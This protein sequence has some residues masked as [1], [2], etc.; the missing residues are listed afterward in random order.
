V[1][2]IV[3]RV[4]GQT[5]SFEGMAEISTSEPVGYPPR[6]L[7]IVIISPYLEAEADLAEVP[8]TGDGDGFGLRS[9]QSGRE[10]SS[11]DRDNGNHDQ[12]LDKREGGTCS[13][14]KRPGGY[15]KLSSHTNSSY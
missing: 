11:Q 12:E 6:E 4:D 10:Q 1:P 9:G 2:D 3:F 14:F 15:G 7:V 13:R 8:D 5:L